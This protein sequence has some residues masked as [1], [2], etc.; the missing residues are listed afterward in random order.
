MGL[1]IHTVR[2]PRAQNDSLARLGSV[3]NLSRDCCAGKLSR[4]EYIRKEEELGYSHV[5][6]HHEIAVKCL[7]SKR[8]FLGPDVDHFGESLKKWKT[9]EDYLKRQ[10]DKVGTKASHHA[11]HFGKYWDKWCMDEYNR[12]HKDKKK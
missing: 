9:F 2:H 4:E 7:E 6:K 8:W 11:E 1:L 5:R 12:L 10:Q 3:K